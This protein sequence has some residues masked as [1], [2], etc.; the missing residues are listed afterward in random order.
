[1]FNLLNE[2]IF[3]GGRMLTTLALLCFHSG[4]DTD[5]PIPPTKGPVTPMDIC[6]EPRVF[7]AVA[8]IRGETFFFKDR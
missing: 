2:D 3:L 4:I 8:Q 7:D 6:K 5:K 1:M